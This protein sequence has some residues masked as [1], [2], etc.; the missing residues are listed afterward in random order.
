[1]NRTAILFVP[2]LG[3]AGGVERL[4]TSLAQH[5]LVRDYTVRIAC[6]AAA[7]ENDLFS[8]SRICLDLLRTSRNPFH[9]ARALKRYQQ[10]AV[11]GAAWLAFDLKS[12]FYYG[13][14]RSKN[15]FCLHLTDPPSLLSADITKA[16]WA[17]A[18]RLDL[19]KQFPLTRRIRGELA[20]RVTKRGV[21][22][23]YRTIVMTR[24]IAEEVRSLYGV[25]PCIVPPGVRKPTDR[26]TKKNNG[27]CF[28]ILSASRLE[29]S[30]RID[31][32]LLAIAKLLDRKSGF[33]RLDWGFDIVGTGGSEGFLRNLTAQLGIQ[34]RVVFHGQVPD[35]RLNS[36]YDSAHV[37]VMPAVQGYGLPALEALAHK[38]PVIVHR[39]SGVSEFLCESP[40]ILQ[41][42]DLNN[43]LAD[44][45]EIMSR[46]TVC[47]EFRLQNAPGVRTELEWCE[48]IAH[49]FCGPP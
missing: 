45:L 5:L 49:L 22:K 29:N 27:N 23:A 14:I 30:K 26:A 42:D 7:P 8:D 43:E 34:D 39:N 4:I 46:R 37:F 33:A 31:F 38:L 32:V 18:K 44:A 41:I 35:K 1:M 2:S 15:S 17:A 6:F 19:N 10:F 3:R 12:A 13:L 16:S 21:A 36:L 40:W 28:R 11:V 9:E 47:G 20:H 48:E 24:R 25:E